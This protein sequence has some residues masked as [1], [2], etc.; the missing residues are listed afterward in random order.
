MPSFCP[1]L[2]FILAFPPCIGLFRNIVAVVAVVVTVVLPF[3][4]SLASFRVITIVSLCIV[5]CG[6][7]MVATPRV[8][9]ATAFAF[10]FALAF[11]IYRYGDEDHSCLSLIPPPVTHLLRPNCRRLDCHP[12]RCRGCGCQSSGASRDFMETAALTAAV[13]I[14]P[15]EATLEFVMPW[16]KG[17]NS[18]KYLIRN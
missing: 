12:L 18:D 9:S 10:N 8:Q 15:A 14:A 16:S 6:G 7:A 1:R 4:S 11:G 2:L 17:Q 13:T 3:P 5:G